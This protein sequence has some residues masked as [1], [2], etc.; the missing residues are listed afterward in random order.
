MKN[1]QLAAQAQLAADILRTGH[2]LGIYIHQD[3]MDAEPRKRVANCKQCGAEFS[4][5]TTVQI[6]CSPNCSRHAIND[7]YRAKLIDKTC[8]VCSSP[9]QSRQPLQKCCSPQCLN[10]RTKKRKREA[11]RKP[12]NGPCSCIRCGSEF[13]QK[14][15]L[16]KFC[17][18]QCQRKIAGDYPE[19]KCVMCGRLFKP[20]RRDAKTCGPECLSKRQA[21]FN[22]RLKVDERD[23]L[24]AV[25]GEDSF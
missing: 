25:F 12:L 4:K 1:E 10:E 21:A 9:F 18:P 17:S 22:T 13:D 3:D 8:E 20:F 24:R 23:S 14:H 5:N 16:Q 19:A 6:Y 15:Y 2:S 7:R 11:N